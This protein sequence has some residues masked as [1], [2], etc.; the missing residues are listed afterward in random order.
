MVDREKILNVRM[1]G[2]EMEMVKELADASGLSQSDTI[3]QLVRR[4]HEELS[5]KARRKKR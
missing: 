1:T 4:A 5:E 2:D 3:R